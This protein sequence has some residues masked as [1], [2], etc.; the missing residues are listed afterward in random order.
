MAADLDLDRT[1]NA[2]DTLPIPHD[3]AARHERA[4]ELLV[5]A[6]GCS[7]PAT[8]SRLRQEAV[9]LTLDLPER[10]ARRYR[11][12]G[13]DVED[14][15]QVGRMA[16]VKAANGYRVGCGNGFA[17]YALPTILGEVK[18]HFRDCGWAVRP[19][20]RLQET[21]AQVA[22]EEERLTQDLHRWPTAHELAE[23]LA[24]DVD[25]VR[26]ARESAAAYTA[27]SLDLPTDEG[28]GIDVVARESAD[29]ERLLRLRVMCQGVARLSERE[30]LI[31]H[32]R[33]VEEKTQAEIG[34]VLGVSQM[35]VSRLLASILATL[36]RELVDVAE[37]A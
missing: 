26:G 35:Q 20:R 7:D 31:V 18:R 2:P 29:I 33:F 16:L 32:L 4:D 10:V 23:A 27:A 12:R 3:V 11:G 13:I 34:E 15:V 1:P 25:E 30:R 19:P 6:A 14:L 21:R 17:S 8:S 28:G 37:A 22:A 36:R 5:Q 9:L 24:V